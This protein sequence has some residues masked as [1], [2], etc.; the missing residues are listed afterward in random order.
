MYKKII[1]A[2]LNRGSRYKRWH[3]ICKTSQCIMQKT[4]SS[5]N[6]IVP[7]PVGPG[8][9]QTVPKTKDPVGPKTNWALRIEP[10]ISLQ[11]FTMPCNM[12]LF[13]RVSSPSQLM[14]ARI[15]HFPKHANHLKTAQYATEKHQLMDFILHTASTRVLKVSFLSYCA[16]V[17]V[18]C[19]I[20]TARSLILIFKKDTI[21]ESLANLR[22]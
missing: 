2:K 16:Q 4:N 1:K 18:H 11:P 15:K 3:T 9:R 6:K 19:T 22:I 7:K 17:V 21:T 13:L 5:Q 12:F 20:S 14:K 8:C 10:E